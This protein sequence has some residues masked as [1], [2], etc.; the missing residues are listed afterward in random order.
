[1]TQVLP[2]LRKSSSR[3]DQLVTWLWIDKNSFSSLIPATTGRIKAEKDQDLKLA[4]LFLTITL[5]HYNFSA[6]K[7]CLTFKVKWATIKKKLASLKGLPDVFL[8]DRRM[9]TKG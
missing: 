8:Q 6:R 5:Y 1:M 7:F 9:K 3:W 4:L 2:R